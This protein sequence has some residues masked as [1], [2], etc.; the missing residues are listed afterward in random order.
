[1]FVG[2]VPR[3]TLYGAYRRFTFAIQSYSLLS[4]ECAEVR[5]D[6]DVALDGAV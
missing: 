4:M 1:M 5:V 3:L 2:S 6:R